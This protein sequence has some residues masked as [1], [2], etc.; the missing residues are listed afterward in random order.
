MRS[1]NPKSGIRASFPL[2]AGP[3]PILLKAGGSVKNS[4]MLLRYCLQRPR[5]IQILLPIVCG[6]LGNMSCQPVSA[7]GTEVTGHAAERRLST[8]RTPATFAV[9]G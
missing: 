5:I 3:E 9:E 1:G 2:R 7:A 4:L 8:L 6:N